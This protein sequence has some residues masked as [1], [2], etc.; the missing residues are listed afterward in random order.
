MQLEHELY[1]VVVEVAAILDDLDE[2]GQA[3]LARGHLGHG[4]GGVELPEN[5]ER[6]AGQR[7]HRG[8][9]VRA[10][11]QPRPQLR[12]PD[13]VTEALGGDSLDGLALPPPVG[14]WD[15]VLGPGHQWALYSQVGCPRAVGPRR[16]A[17]GESGL[18]FT[19]L[20]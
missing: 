9:E 7:E 15:S 20:K 17:T 14:H 13:V 4:D 19:N 12:S 16:V 18:S 1:G 6:Q 11:L 8:W 10:V 2:G 3:A 5:C